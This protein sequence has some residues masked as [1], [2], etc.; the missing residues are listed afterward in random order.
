[1]IYVV[2]FTRME[3]IPYVIYGIVYREL[4]ISAS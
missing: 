1:M 3:E 2:D 4:S